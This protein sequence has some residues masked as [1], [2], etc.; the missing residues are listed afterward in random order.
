MREREEPPFRSIHLHGGPISI[1]LSS[2]ALFLRATDDLTNSN[3]LDE[4]KDN[5]GTARPDRDIGKFM[6][7]E[8]SGEAVGERV[9]K[10]VGEAVGDANLAEPKE[11]QEHLMMKVGDEGDAHDLAAKKQP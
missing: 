3:I 10:A 6:S 4:T 5:Y 1:A 7:E 2:E 9:D 8:T 11:K